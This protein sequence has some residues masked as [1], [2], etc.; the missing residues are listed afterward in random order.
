MDSNLELIIENILL[1][2]P[3]LFNRLINREVTSSVI[4]QGSHSVLAI[5]EKKHSASMSEI[6][7]ELF[8]PKPN[9]TALVDKLVDVRMV[10]RISDSSD[11]RI[12]RIKITEFGKESIDKARILLVENIK[13]KLKLLS[14]ND[15]D[16]LSD[17]LKVVKEV[18]QKIQ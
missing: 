17:S 7:K 4:P 15:L 2:K 16:R 12:V 11:R 1:L 6:G 8:M 18:I 5:L 10:E 9:A 3:L 13:S 14:E